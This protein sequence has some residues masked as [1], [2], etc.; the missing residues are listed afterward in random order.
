MIYKVAIVDDS[1]QIIASLAD[2]LMSTKQVEIV[3]K[4]CN[5]EDLLAKLK[6]IP[7]EQ[8]PQVILMDIEMPVMNGIETVK[9]CSVLYEYIKFIMLTVF[10]DDDKI[11]EAIKAG[12]DGYLLKDEQT[13]SI[14]NAITE[15]LEQQGAPMSPSIARKI[16]NLLAK[17]TPSVVPDTNNLTERE[18]EILN[19]LVAGL[20]YKQIA[21]QLF[22]SPFTVRNHITK[23]YDKL[24]VSSKTDAIKLAI[25]N[26]WV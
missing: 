1:Y 5:G 15:V 2:E 25:K 3:L 6:S 16:L 17:S 23:M 21:A 13:A 19:G 12:A 4:A 18:M 20:D 24:H 26:R 9:I 7:I 22:I 14:I 8:H 10:D 11:F